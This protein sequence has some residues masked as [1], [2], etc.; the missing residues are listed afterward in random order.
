MMQRVATL[1]LCL[2]VVN[3]GISLGAGVY[4]SR[5]VVPQWIDTSDDGAYHWNAEAARRADTGLRFWAFVTTGPLTLLTLGNLVAA[6]KAR[7]A[8]RGWWLAAA[9]AALAD[10]L[11]TFSYFIPTLI[12]LMRE[13]SVADSRAV[14][15]AVQWATLNYARH[16]IV[17]VA[18]LSALRAF[19]FRAQQTGPADAQP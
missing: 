8:G 17:L 19:W 4:E 10:R 13:E 1:L 7:G 6:W 2:F 11:F 14:A 15:M 5:I 18:L 12:R 3:L 16:A 9:L